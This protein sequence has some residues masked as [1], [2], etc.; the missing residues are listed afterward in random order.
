MKANADAAMKGEKISKAEWKP[1]ESAPK[2]GKFYFACN[3]NTGRVCIENKPR[4]C[5]PGYWTKAGNKWCGMANSLEA[6]HWH[7]CPALPNPRAS[8]MDKQ[9]QKQKLH[10]LIVAA[11]ESLPARYNKDRV[12][13]IVGEILGRYASEWEFFASISVIGLALETLQREADETL[14]TLAEMK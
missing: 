7:P 11:I 2:T 9:S 13:E 5:A 8:E 10:D 4:G 14:D 1:I 3:I 12:G 6:T